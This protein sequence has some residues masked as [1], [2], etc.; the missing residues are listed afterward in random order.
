MRRAE[1]AAVGEAIHDAEVA[2]HD[3]DTE[4]PADY[5]MAQYLDGVIEGLRQSLVV[6]GEGAEQ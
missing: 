4:Q 2:L 5:L 3:L 6:T 1:V